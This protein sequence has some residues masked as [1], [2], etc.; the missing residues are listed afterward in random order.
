MLPWLLDA[1]YAA[2]LIAAAPWLAY[3]RWVQRKPI[4][5]LREKLPGRI[6]R[7]HPDRPC[8]WFHAVSVG[9]V[10]QL[11]SL[12]ADFLARHPGWEVL[13]TTTTGTGFD[14]ARQK[15][16]QHTIAY[17]PLDFSHAV[18]TA[19]R[20]VR[21]ELVVLVELELWPNFLLAADRLGIPVVLVNARLSAKSYRGYRWLKPVLRP[22][23]RTLSQVAAQ[24]EEYAARLIDL[25]VPADRVTV[26]GNIKYD[27]VQSDRKNAKTAELRASFGL[28]DDAVV[29]IA[30]STQ[31]PEER[32]AMEAY[33]ALRDEFPSLRL[34]VVPR[35]KER[36]EEVTQLISSLKLPIVRRSEK[37]AKPQAMTMPA[38]SE[39]PVLLLDTLGELAA[40]WGLADIAFVGGSLTNR[41]GQNM[42]EPAGY[43]AAVLF[44]PNTWNFRDIVEQLLSRDAAVVIRDRDELR[45][46]VRRLL[47]DHTE[48]QRLGDAA[49]AFVLT[50][51]GATR[52]TLDVIDAAIS[53]PM[54]R[55]F[56]A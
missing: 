44:G 35:H 31:D 22:I 17:W 24:T 6:A 34:V 40:C 26:T 12:V 37:S 41:G 48:R 28:S 29:L 39:Q 27:R 42:L 49:R 53:A 1:I 9:E 21:P 43:G 55:S 14:V 33:L 56:A 18:T 38:G 36:F 7:Q 4:A 25:G 16:P 47:R 32:Y 13:I 23:L 51:Q 19:L 3:R 11:P 50:Q 8:V 45:E 10:L 20:T 2:V 30:G 5:G 52:L 54:C 46:T 15:F